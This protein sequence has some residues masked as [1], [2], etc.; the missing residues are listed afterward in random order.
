M[1]YYGK[2]VFNNVYLKL[3][4]KELIQIDD[5]KIILE[6]GAVIISSWLTPQLRIVDEDSI[7]KQLDAI[8]STVQKLLVDSNNHLKE[9]TISSG[10]GT[11]AEL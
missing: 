1:K 7:Y 9:D 6:E 8:A 11:C 5:D 4:M 2:M 3:R 10:Y